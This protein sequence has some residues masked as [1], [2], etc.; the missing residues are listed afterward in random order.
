MIIYLPDHWKTHRKEGR[1]GI[2]LGRGF[3]PGFSGRNIR[4]IEVGEWAINRILKLHLWA[5]YIVKGELRDLYNSVLSPCLF[6]HCSFYFSFFPLLF[7]YLFHPF[8][9]EQACPFLFILLGHTK[10]TTHPW[11]F[12]LN[13]TS[14][15]G[16]PK[17]I[18]IFMVKLVVIMTM[19][20]F[21]PARV[22]LDIGW[23]DSTNMIISTPHYAL[24]TVQTKAMATVSAVI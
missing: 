11:C 4:Y 5:W 2:A 13:P 9:Q 8:W 22:P 14:Q 1:R 15:Q 6:F 21:W 16:W 23:P 24:Q 18:F 20:V 7:F 17:T 10:V 3:Y 12:Q 19:L